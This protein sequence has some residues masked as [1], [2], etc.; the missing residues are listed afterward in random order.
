MQ[1]YYA[2]LGLNKNASQEEIKSAFRRLAKKHHPDI[3]GDPDKFKAI[4]EA[5]N[6]LG[7]ANKRAEYDNPRSHFRTESMDP[8]FA[9]GIDLEE[10]FRSFAG[11]G[12]PHGRRTQRNSNI[13]VSISIPLAS[14]VDDQIKIIKIGGNSGKEIEVNIPRGIRSGA[15]ISYK[16]L[17]NQEVKN[18]PPGDLLVE[19]NVLPDAR[20][21]RQE[22]NLYSDLTVNAIDA[23]LG[24]HVMFTTIHGK[25]LRIN[26]PKGVQHGTVL[27]L[28]NEGLPNRKDGARGDQYLRILI[29]IPTNLTKAQLDLLAQL[30]PDHR[31]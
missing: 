22:Y 2:T 4:N 28:P 30:K 1:D 15:V 17:G 3:G 11:A 25:E 31:R 7:D 23:M 21:E 20:F 18:L 12:F 24:T 6:V 5:Y 27:R 14:L 19:V 13:R 10:F 9:Y 16:G 8:G 26:I 29:L